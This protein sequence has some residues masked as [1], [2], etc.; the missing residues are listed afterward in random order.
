MQKDFQLSRP[1]V[2]AG[3]AKHH[4][5]GLLLVLP[6][7]KLFLCNLT[8]KKWSILEF[9]LQLGNVPFLSGVPT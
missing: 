2:D 3:V 1:L 7:L 8:D 9:L 5:I 6:F 4:H